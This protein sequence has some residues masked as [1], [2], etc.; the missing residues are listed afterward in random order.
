MHMFHEFQTLVSFSMAQA[1][2]QAPFHHMLKGFVLHVVVGV[3]EVNHAKMPMQSS[4][5]LWVL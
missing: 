2:I 5:S 3:E 4:D 1:V